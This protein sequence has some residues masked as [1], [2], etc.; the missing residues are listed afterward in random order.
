MRRAQPQYNGGWGAP[1]DPTPSLASLMRSG[2]CAFDPTASAQ[3]RGPRQ[4]HAYSTKPAASPATPDPLPAHTHRPGLTMDPVRGP[5]WALVR[6]QSQARWNRCGCGWGGVHKHHCNCATIHLYLFLCHEKN[7][8][9]NNV[10][11]SVFRI[12][13]AK[14][15]PGRGLSRAFVRR[16]AAC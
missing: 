15:S 10:S 13:K 6:C 11:P 12:P 7:K 2:P 3:P 5:S 4:P 8:T 16:T 1:V 9:K 14:L